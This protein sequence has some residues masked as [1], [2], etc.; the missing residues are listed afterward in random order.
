MEVRIGPK[1]KL[2][3][4]HVA[5]DDAQA[6][7]DMAP[8]GQ[9]FGSPDYVRRMD[10]DEAA[11]SAFQSWELVRAW[12]AEPHPGFDGLSP[13]DASQNSDGLERAIVIPK[14]HRS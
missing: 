4:H 7:L 6:W 1:R 14:A 9:E 12:L 11:L 3:P 13:E 5:S 2:R 10:L 8:V